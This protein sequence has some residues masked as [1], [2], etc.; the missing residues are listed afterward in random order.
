MAAAVIPIVLA[1]APLLQPLITSLVTHVEHLF[2][3]KTGKTKFDLVLGA[4]TQAAEQLA[5][6]GKIPGVLDAQSIAAMIQTVVT[7]LQA[8]RNPQP[9]VSRSD[10][11]DARRTHR[12]CSPWAASN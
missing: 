5:T 3:A 1:A 8:R 12:P 2:G 11:R 4:V 10:C 7:D 9:R 6:A